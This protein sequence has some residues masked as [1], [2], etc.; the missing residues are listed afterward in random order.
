MLNM[1][2]TNRNWRYHKELSMWLTKDQTLADPI[3]ISMEAE[4]G[5]YVFFNQNAWQRIRV[6]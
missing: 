2:R 3:P 1:N 6:F 5:S 4:K